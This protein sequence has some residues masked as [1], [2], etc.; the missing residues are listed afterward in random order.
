MRS[1]KA[2]HHLVV[3][4]LALVLAGAVMFTKADAAQAFGPYAVT[5]LRVIDGDTVEVEVS[6]W[7]DDYKRV[8][9]RVA[10][11]NAPELHPRMGCGA[12]PPGAAQDACKARAACESSAAQRARDFTRQFL[13]AGPV[14]LDN[15]A[16]DKYAGRVLGDLYVGE[17]SLAGALIDS[18]HA[19]IYDGGGRHAW[20]D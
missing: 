15:V 7:P 1:G 11:V 13:A 18:G 14:A 6:V 12:M 16:P 8:S 4:A 20:C 5:V 17:Q 3:I 19:V 10:G 9:V 2:L